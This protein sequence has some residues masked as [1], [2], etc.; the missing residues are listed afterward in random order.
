[1]D[2]DTQSKDHDVIELH[3]KGIDSFKDLKPFI[4]AYLREQIGKAEAK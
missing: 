1:M 4:E 3:F 2:F